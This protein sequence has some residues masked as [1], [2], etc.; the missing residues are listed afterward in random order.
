MA[1]AMMNPEDEDV[2]QLLKP[3][4]QAS[5]LH[6]L[7]FRTG[8]I[9]V[10]DSTPSNTPTPRLC[11]DTVEKDFSQQPVVYTPAAKS[12]IINQFCREDIKTVYK[13]GDL[14]GTGTYG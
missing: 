13:F 14:V 6:K 1:G 5:N 10:E 9:E 2:L 11:F 7:E 12:Q 4:H 8:E 3:T